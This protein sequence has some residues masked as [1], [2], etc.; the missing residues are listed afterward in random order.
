MPIPQTAYGLVLLLLIAGTARSQQQPAVYLYGHVRKRSGTDPLQSVTVRNINQQKNNRSDLGG[1]YKIPAAKGDTLIFSSAGYIPDTT[2]VNTWMFQEQGGYTVYMKPNL[3]TL[4][5][6]TVDESS[7]YTRDS[8]ERVEA[9]GWINDKNKVHKEKLVGGKRF[10]DGVGLSLSPIAYFSAKETQRRRF[11]KKLKTDEKEYYIDYK[12]GRPY[13]AR[14]TGLHG[15][16]LQTFMIH[17]RPRYEF[18]RRASQDDMLNY[19]NECMK[20]FKQGGIP[21]L[22]GTGFIFRKMPTFPA[23]EI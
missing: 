11:R 19:I 3:V 20:K 14:I 13:V 7:N 5:S 18:C 15:D 10:S 17:F 12:F 4:P 21:I 1:N 2:I 6:Y 9:Y 23:C 22:T 8:L 16:S